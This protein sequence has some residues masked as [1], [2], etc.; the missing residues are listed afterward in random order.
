[1]LP[2]DDTVVSA[3]L[4][5]TTVANVYDQLLSSSDPN[6]KMLRMT[7]RDSL[8]SNYLQ[9]AG[10]NVPL[11]SRQLL[12]QPQRRYLMPPFDTQPRVARLFHRRHSRTIFRTA[13]TGDWLFS[14]SVLPKFAKRFVAKARRRPRWDRQ[15]MQL[16]PPWEPSSASCSGFRTPWEWASPSSSLPMRLGSARLHS[17]K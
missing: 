16:W 7:I 4:S 12:L 13:K 6:A 8:P 3:F 9:R 10:I 5:P 15:S 2:L 17:A 14:R 1:M 11:R